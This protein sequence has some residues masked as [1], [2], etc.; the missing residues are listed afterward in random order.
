MQYF[1]IYPSYNFRFQL[2][3]E[4]S[5]EFSML[6]MR[7]NVAQL[8]VLE[9]SHLLFSRLSST[10]FDK[11]NIYSFICQQVKPGTINAQSSVFRMAEST[12]NRRLIVGNIHVL[13]NPK[14]GEIKLG[15]VKIFLTLIASLMQYMSFILC[16]DTA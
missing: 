8:C 4:R 5:F 7:N 12:H 13:F 15:Q 2:L 16:M 10:W 1:I 9:V 11:L 6:G 3:Q 14:R